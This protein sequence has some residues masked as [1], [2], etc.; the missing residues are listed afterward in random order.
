[1]RKILVELD[2][3]E[4]EGQLL[5]EV[6][7]C[8][9]EVKAWS[10]GFA[11]RLEDLLKEVFTIRCVICDAGLCGVSSK[12]GEEVLKVP[13]LAHAEIDTKHVPWPSC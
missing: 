6:G 13:I 12:L 1:L 11:E 4:D 7:E 3:P 5:A 2:V 9:N 8:R 10:Y